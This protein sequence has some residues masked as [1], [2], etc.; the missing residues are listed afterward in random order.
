MGYIL[1]SLII[2]LF[3][4]GTFPI[5]FSLTRTTPIS[6]KK[7]RRLCII[8]TFV[9]WFGFM[10]LTNNQS[11]GGAAIL[12][13]TVFYNVG[14]TNLQKKNLLEDCPPATDATVR[15][16]SETDPQEDL[17]KID[18]DKE[19]LKAAKAAERK[20]SYFLSL[21]QFD[22]ELK[23]EAEKNDMSVSEYRRFCKKQIQQYEDALRQYNLTHSDRAEY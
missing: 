11:K 13:G 20:A 14:K 22:K 15:N 3:L 1:I 6:S 19:R 7:Y 8:V 16:S 9:V 21:S 18:E 23:E 12:W 17:P 4:Y 2:T 10:M 5:A